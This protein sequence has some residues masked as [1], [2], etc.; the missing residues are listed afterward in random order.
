MATDRTCE[1]AVHTTLL[2]SPPLSSNFGSPDCSA[3][4]LERTVSRSTDEQ[5]SEIREL[6][7]L[8]VLLARSVANYE[9]HIQTITNSVVLLTSRVP[10]LNRSSIPFLP[11]WFSFAEMEQN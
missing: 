3:L 1:D 2:G 5:L 9:N 7:L 11:K 10:T 6:L 8:L 4:D